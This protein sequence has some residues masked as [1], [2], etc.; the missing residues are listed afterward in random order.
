M[1]LYVDV[2]PLEDMQ[3]VISVL[4]YSLGIYKLLMHVN[5]LSIIGNDILN[6]SM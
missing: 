3:T 2:Q 6:V 1:V 5:S 4:V